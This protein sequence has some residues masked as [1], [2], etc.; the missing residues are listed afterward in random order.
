MAAVGASIGIDSLNMGTR[1]AAVFD[2]VEQ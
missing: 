2:F 1:K